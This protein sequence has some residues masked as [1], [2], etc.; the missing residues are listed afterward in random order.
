MAWSGHSLCTWQALGAMPELQGKQ[1]RA[2]TLEQFVSTQAPQLEKLLADHESWARANLADYTPRPD[3][4]AF[5][6]A[7][8]TP[9]RAR[10][11][12]AL[13]LNPLSRLGLFLQLQPGD[14]RADRPRLPWVDITA[15]KSGIAARENSYFALT[16]GETVAAIDVVATAAYEPDYGLDIGLFDDNGTLNGQSYGFGKQPF[17]DNRLDYSSQAPF[18]MGFHHESRLI[19]AAAGFLR[20]THPEA[21]IELFSALARHAFASGHDYWGW[22]FTG[23]AMHYVQDLTQPYHAT[24]LPGLSTARMIGINLLAM[25]GYE[26]PKTNAINLVSNRHMAI[27]GY[28]FQ[29]MSQALQQGRLDDALLVA[30]RDTRRDKEHWK[31]QWTATRNLVSREAHE[32]ADEVDAQLERSFPTRYTSDPSVMLGMDADKIDFYAVAKGHSAEQNT[33]LEQQLVPLMERLG[34]HSRALVRAVATARP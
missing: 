18:H 31:Y 4:L 8:T 1:V 32:S 16:E 24:V 21:R 6:A 2:E 28:Q 22:R 3:A 14:P 15:L 20:H 26:T 25:A 13:R 17:G 30:A 29:R 7:D 19:Y 5:K 12:K 9:V 11:L 23:W 34:R 33:R 10:F 27:E